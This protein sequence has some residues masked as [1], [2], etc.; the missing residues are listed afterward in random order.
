MFGE[1]LTTRGF[2]EVSV[3]NLIPTQSEILPEECLQV[4]FQLSRA[5]HGGFGNREQQCSGGHNTSDH[6]NFTPGAFRYIV[7]GASF[8]LLTWNCR[9]YIF[10]CRPVRVTPAPPC[11]PSVSVRHV[12]LAPALRAPAQAPRPG[13]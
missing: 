8:Q 4:R 12:Q 2:I 5:G 1:N 7:H 11:A 6:G 13:W 3:H 9:L 10:R